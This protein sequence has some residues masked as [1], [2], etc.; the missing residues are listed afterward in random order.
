MR[1]TWPPCEGPPAASMR[2]SN[3][4]VNG[5]DGTT[6]ANKKNFPGTVLALGKVT[7]DDASELWKYMKEQTG[8]ADPT[9]NFNGKFL[10]SKTGKVSVPKNLEADIE[11]LMNE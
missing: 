3:N 8:A 1:P 7:G 5:G 6:F 9:W 2:N 11:A 4:S 10:I